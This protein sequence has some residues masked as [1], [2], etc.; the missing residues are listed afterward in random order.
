MPWGSSIETVYGCP[1][2]KLT[3]GTLVIPPAIISAIVGATRD[4]HEWLALF[5]GYTEQDGLVGIVEE[6]LVPG[7]Q[8][9]T[10]STCSI[11]EKLMAPEDRVGIIG[12][13]HSHHSMSAKFSGTDLGVGG[14]CRQ[15]P[16]SLV[17]GSS[18]PYTK[19][20]EYDE[21]EMLGISYQLVIR[22]RAACG[23][24]LKSPGKIVPAGY[25]DWP[26]GITPEE[27]P[28]GTHG[29][30]E[31]DV[32]DL[33]DCQRYQE[34]E[35]STRYKIQRQANCGVKETNLHN[36]RKIF[37]MTGDEI[38]SLLPPPT[39]VVTH[40]SHTQYSAGGQKMKLLGEGSAA[41]DHERQYPDGPTPEEW[42]RWRALLDDQDAYD[43]EAAA[44]DTQEFELVRITD[45]VC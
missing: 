28:V 34:G 42:E 10:G 5:R 39:P 44:A 22:H 35:G 41:D 9:R 19:G 11:D 29:W 15:Y 13:V 4:S 8:K 18:M 2:A 32:K 30:Y 45:E 7:G 31:F 33:E 12:V 24:Y 3:R 40:S 27:V 17:V 20:D 25:D 21:A 36:R 6:L 1:I 43:A 16:I 37:G 23:A 26:F 38:I 14:L